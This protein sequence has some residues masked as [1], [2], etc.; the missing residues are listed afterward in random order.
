LSY[1]RIGL[2]IR[3][4]PHPGQAKSPGGSSAAAV[5]LIA[6]R[7]SRPRARRPSPL[8]RGSRCPA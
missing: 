3:I 5:E 8:S 4:S 7:P 1:G 2:S 6:P